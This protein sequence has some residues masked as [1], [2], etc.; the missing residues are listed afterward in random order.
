MKILK[1][2]KLLNWEIEV[3]KNWR[4]VFFD[5]SIFRF[6]IVLFLLKDWRIESEDWVIEKWKYNNSINPM[7]QY[8][9]KSKNRK[10]EK[11]NNHNN[12]INSI[13]K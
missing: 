13:T 10:I 5:F 11:Y 2:E 4:I 9:R 3:L 8:N 1:S 7:T 12:P 6:T